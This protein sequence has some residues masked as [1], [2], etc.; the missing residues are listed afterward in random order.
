MEVIR[1][2]IIAVVGII[3]AAVL[4]TAAIHFIAF[5]YWLFLIIIH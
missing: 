3:I 2:L 4:F 5:M 1:E